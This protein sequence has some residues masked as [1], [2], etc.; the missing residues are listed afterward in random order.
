MVFIYVVRDFKW[1][2]SL[3]GKAPMTWMIARS[4]RNMRGGYFLGSNLIV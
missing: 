4:G 2:S 3:A 1:R